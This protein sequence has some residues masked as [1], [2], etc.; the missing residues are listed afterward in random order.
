MYDTNTETTAYHNEQLLM[1]Q[2]SYVNP[3]LSTRT[4]IEN[5]RVILIEFY[6]C[7]YQINL[8]YCSGEIRLG[9]GERLNYQL[10]S[11]KCFDT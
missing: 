1:L 7:Y 4:R 5:A 9:S 2:Q 11:T 8:E 3:P 6:L 10:V